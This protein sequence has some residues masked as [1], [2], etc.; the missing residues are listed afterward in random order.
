MNH[1]APV[2]TIV[3]SLLKTGLPDSSQRKISVRLKQQ[4]RA[5]SAPKKYLPDNSQSSFLLHGW[6][7]NIEEE[8][9]QCSLMGEADS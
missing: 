4:L 6:G 2:T 8:P 1:P 7:Q 5:S 3:F 9:P